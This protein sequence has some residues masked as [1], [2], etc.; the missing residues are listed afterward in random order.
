MIKNVKS[1]F[2]ENEKVMSST[3]RSYCPFRIQTHDHQAGCTLKFGKTNR[4][5]T[6][7][8]RPL[9]LKRNFFVCPITGVKIGFLAFNRLESIFNPLIRIQDEYELAINVW[10][11]LKGIAHPKNRADT[12]MGT[13][14]VNLARQVEAEVSNIILEL[15]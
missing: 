6:Q 7:E 1:K 11:T 8:N 15:E 10:P 14:M 9:L 5:Y 13:D 2:K 4:C 12:L 3:T